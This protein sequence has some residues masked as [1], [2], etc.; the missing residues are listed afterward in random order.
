MNRTNKKKAGFTLVELLVA[1]LCATLAITMIVGTT[2]FI[3]SSTNELI[4]VGSESYQVKS[5]KDYILSQNHKSNPQS[6]YVV[7]DEENTLSHNDTVISKETQIL[8]IEFSDDENFIYCNL[9]FQ[10]ESYRFV[11]GTK[12][13][14]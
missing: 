4:Q 14:G 6:E 1:M 7:N 3:T 13:G 5:I 8:K 9:V 12:K 2:L 10:D 11:A